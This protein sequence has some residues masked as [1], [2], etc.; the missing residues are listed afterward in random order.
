MVIGNSGVG[1]TSLIKRY[2][3]GTFAEDTS[4]TAQMEIYA[5]T[6]SN[7]DGL[8]MGL[9]IWDTAGQERFRTL[10]KQ[11]YRGSEFVVLCYAINDLS[12]FEEC[13]S[14]LN[15]LLDNEFTFFNRVILVGTKRDC[16]RKVSWQDGYNL[17]VDIGCYFCETSSK[18]NFNVASVFSLILNQLNNDDKVYRDFSKCTKSSFYDQL[19]QKESLFT[20]LPEVEGC[21]R[22]LTA[23]SDANDGLTINLNAVNDESNVKDG[24]SCFSTCA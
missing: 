11:Y 16:E 4:S 1:K 7:D 15:E 14:W 23:K 13:N 12:S 21:T 17:S 10:N 5:T 24:D 18:D 20:T 6:R 8:R 3:S 19:V 22:P 9:N 2:S